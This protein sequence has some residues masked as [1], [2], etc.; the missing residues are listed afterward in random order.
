[1]V[2]YT[3]KM[4]ASFFLNLVVCRI[5]QWEPAWWEDFLVITGVVML[6]LACSRGKLR[7]GDI[8]SIVSQVW[9][10]F[11]F[12]PVGNRWLSYPYVL[13]S[14]EGWCLV[15]SLIREMMFLCSKAGCFIFKW[16]TQDL[17]HGMASITSC[18]SLKYG[19]WKEEIIG[20]LRLYELGVDLYGTCRFYQ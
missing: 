14:I 3:H 8:I 15:H 6:F 12:G 16:R 11:H 17:A 4:F 18:F 7:D 5:R 13:Y 2:S 9:L 1:M 19:I 20:L 10:W